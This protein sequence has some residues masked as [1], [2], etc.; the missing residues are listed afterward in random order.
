MMMLVL[1]DWMLETTSVSWLSKSRLGG[2]KRRIER[3]DSGTETHTSQEEAKKHAK[4]CGMQGKNP[5]G[6]KKVK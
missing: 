2:K 4:D 5:K 3:A 1:T 6:T